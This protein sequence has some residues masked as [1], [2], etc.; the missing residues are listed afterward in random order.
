MSA[1]NDCRKSVDGM[2]S[3]P[4]ILDAAACKWTF[5]GA[6]VYKRKQ[7][8]EASVQTPCFEMASEM[9]HGIAVVSGKVVKT[10]KGTLIDYI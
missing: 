2:E 3:V 8:L 7:T 5:T 9:E 4:A 6:A 10:R 1:A